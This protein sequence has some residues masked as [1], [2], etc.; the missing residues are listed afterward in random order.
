MPD[1]QLTPEFYDLVK[2][3]QIHHYSKNCHKYKNEKC[4]FHFGQYFTDCTIL[5]RP[6][7]A[8]LSCAKKKEILSERSRLLQVLSEYINDQLS[9]L[10]H[11]I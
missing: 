10:K 4:C 3:Y 1:A 11:N 2:S 6:L 7:E 9:P 8:T 5:A